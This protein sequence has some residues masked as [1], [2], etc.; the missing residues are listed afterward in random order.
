MSCAKLTRLYIVHN[1]CCSTETVVK[2]SK[3]S[4]T[5][6]KAGSRNNNETSHRG[7][8]THA[9]PPPSAPP[10]ASPRRRA[11]QEPYTQLHHRLHE[12]GPKHGSGLLRVVP[13]ENAFDVYAESCLRGWASK[14]KSQSR[15][16]TGRLCDIYVAV[17]GAPNFGP[18][19]RD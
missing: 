17:S 5:R 6:Y 4:A 14:T 3:L 16:E 7:A 10:S 1:E 9:R 19:S 12:V 15:L 11:L 13:T 2:S 18:L 8:H